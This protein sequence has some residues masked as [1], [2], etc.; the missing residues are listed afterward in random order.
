MIAHSCPS[1]L[2]P[3]HLWSGALQ[4]NLWEVMSDMGLLDKVRPVD[5]LVH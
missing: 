5:T 2:V 3:Y 4:D 1:L